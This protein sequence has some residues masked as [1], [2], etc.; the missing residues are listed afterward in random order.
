MLEKYF[1]KNERKTKFSPK[2]ETNHFLS[3]FYVLN[4]TL[5]VK[6][7]LSVMLTKL[8]WLG[9]AKISIC[10]SGV[11]DFYPRCFENPRSTNCTS[12]KIMYFI[13][14]VHNLQFYTADLF[15]LVSRLLNRHGK[16][17]LPNPC[18]S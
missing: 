15:S 11:Y 6:L 1:K 7:S 4:W 16:I 5:I 3:C 8:K 9:G 18:G 13:P 12:G 10:T 14:S 17:N 2:I